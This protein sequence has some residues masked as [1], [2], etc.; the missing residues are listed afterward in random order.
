MEENKLYVK[1]TKPVDQ[2]Q[3]KKQKKYRQNKDYSKENFRM[4]K[5]CFPNV[6]QAVIESVLIQC[7]DE[8]TAASE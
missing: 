7:E 8:M 1:P 2:F 3:R 5:E 4:L 6:D